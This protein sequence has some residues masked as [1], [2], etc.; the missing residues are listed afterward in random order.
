ML[1]P[2]AGSSPNRIYDDVAVPPRS[3]IA[4][5]AASCR[6]L[7]TATCILLA[8]L[9]HQNLFSVGFDQGLCNADRARRIFHIDNRPIVFRLDFHRRVRRRCGCATDQQRQGE[10]LPLHFTGDMHHFIKRRCDQPGEPNNFRTFA[11]RRLQNLLA[12]HHHAKINDFKVIALQH[13]ANNIFADVVHIA[14]HGRHDDLA[15]DS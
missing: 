7:L 15:I 14:F 8:R 13:D 11:A 4:E 12:G 3:T 9:V 2:A 5:R 1:A 6:M 10:I